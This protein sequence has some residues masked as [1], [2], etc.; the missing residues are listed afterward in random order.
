MD[1]ETALLADSATTSVATQKDI[2]STIAHEVAHQWFGNLVTMRWWDD[3]WLNEGFAT[4]METHPLAASR[5][6]WNIPVDDARA[7]QTAL[8]VD[9]LRSTRA[10]HTS[11]QTPN[12]IESL[13][14]VIS[15]QKGSALLRMIEHYVGPDVFRDGITTASP[16]STASTSSRPGATRR[17]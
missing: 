2:A 6:E 4:W 17:A 10:V 16:R 9:S 13:F 5:P 12:Q 1:R 14:D 3:L 8:G 7:T 15:Y 11:V